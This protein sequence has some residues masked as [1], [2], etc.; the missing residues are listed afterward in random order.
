MQTTEDIPV[1]IWC[2]KGHTICICMQDDKRCERECETDTLTRD[3]F[4][5]WKECFERNAYGL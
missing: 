5:G 1:Y 4:R 3:K 2:E